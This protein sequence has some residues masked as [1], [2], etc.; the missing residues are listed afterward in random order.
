[1]HNLPKTLD[2]ICDFLADVPGVEVL[3]SSLEE[4]RGQIEFLVTG[5][6]TILAL[7]HMAMGANVSLQPW[8][9]QADIE[10]LGSQSVKQTFSA[11]TRRRDHFKFGELQMLGVWLVWYHHKV[12]ALTTDA[13]NVQLHYW[14]GA[15]VDA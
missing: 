12:G 8:L 13:A 1:M 10:C 11:S 9:R 5:E 2:Q 4:E 15:R 14:Q 6:T 7:Q 3:G